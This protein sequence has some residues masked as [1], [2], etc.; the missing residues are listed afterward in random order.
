[1]KILFI[2]CSTIIPSFA[3]G[4]F[5]IIYDK[6]SVC[7]VRSSAKTGNN[8]TDKL[9]NGHLIYC[10]ANNTNWINIDYTKNKNELNGQV[11]KDRVIFISTYLEVP[12]LTKEN[13]KI[14]LKKDSI[15]V[16]ITA[17]RFEKSKHKFTFFKETKNQIELIDNKKYWGTDGGVP[18]TEYKSIEVTIGQRKMLL[19]KTAIENLYEPSLYNTEVNYDK[20]N[21]ILYIQSMNSDGAGSYEVIWKIKKGV[22]TDKFIAYGF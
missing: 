4:Q 22:Y 11:Y 20:V 17:K 2:F 3:F 15:K 19:P 16:I 13:F 1:M 21:D 9:K 7:N 10:F 8:I 6:D 14:T 5:A 12:M 18:Q